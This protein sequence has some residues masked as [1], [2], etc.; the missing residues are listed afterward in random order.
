[1]R[2]THTVFA[3]AAHACLL[4]SPAVRHLDAQQVTPTSQLVQTTT[5]TVEILGLERWTVAMLEDSLRKRAGYDLRTQGA[6]ACAATLR[7]DLGFADAAAIMLPKEGMSTYWMV[8]L[9][10]PQDSHRVRYRKLRLA[11]TGGIPEWADVRELMDR[12]VQGVVFGEILLQAA[13]GEKGEVKSPN[14]L[15]AELRPRVDTSILHAQQRLRSW[16]A[17]HKTEQDY[18][19]ALRVLDTDSNMVNRVVALYVILPYLHNDRTWTAIAETLIESDGPV[20]DA[21]F[22]MLQTLVA[23]GKRPKDFQAIAPSLHAILNGTSQMLMPQIVPFLF[24]FQ[25][26]DSLAA[27]LLKNGGTML[28]AYA[29]ARKRIVREP[30][31]GVLRMLSG[32]NYGNDVAQWKAW[33]RSLN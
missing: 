14:E 28:L 3:L 32:K 18:E 1:M 11:K 27:P 8:T 26:G 16:F 25:P 5:T 4:L 2:R 31:I 15:P 9:T 19:T 7:Y 12:Q 29:G 17:D 22:S 30:A 21:G 33:I 23:A 6:H 24:M 20:R 13:R 10:E